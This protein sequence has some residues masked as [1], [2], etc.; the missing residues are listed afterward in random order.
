M[1]SQGAM[2]QGAMM[3]Q[4]GKIPQ[5]AM[6]QSAMIQQRAM[7][8]RMMLQDADLQEA[9][10]QSTKIKKRTS[11]SEYHKEKRR[12]KHQD[13]IQAIGSMDDKNKNLLKTI[14][15][16]KD[17]SKSMKFDTISSPFVLHYMFK[18]D[19]TFN[20]L[21]DNLNKLLKPGGYLIFTTM[22]A[23]L[24]HEEF[25][26]TNGKIESFYTSKEGTKKKFMHV[27]SKYDIKSNIVSI[28]PL[29]KM[30]IYKISSSTFENKNTEKKMKMF[31]DKPPSQLIKDLL[32]K[33]VSNINK[34]EK[35]KK[36]LP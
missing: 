25:Q 9:T 7:L 13:Q 8:Q 17:G 23:E 10:L 1:I 22:D 18:D 16:E 36:T 24:V 30:K 21:C 19:T 14:F 34:E 12:K 29:E 31:A 5:G 15:G 35:K 11:D 33:S 3:L 28:P 27:I 6:S 32:K 26:K 20:N 2:P 4:G